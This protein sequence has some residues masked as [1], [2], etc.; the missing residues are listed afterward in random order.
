MNR[1]KRLLLA[2]LTCGLLILPLQAA[3]T[4][5]TDVW[6]VASEAG[7]GI[8]MIQAD[9]IIFI[10][11]FIYGSSGQPTWVVATMGEDANGNFA[12]DL[13]ATTGTYYGSPWNPINFV[14]T[15]VGTASFFPASPYA[16]TLSYVINGTTV[17]K[18]LQRQTLKTINLAGNYAGGRAGAYSGGNCSTVGE[19]QDNFNLQVSQ[20]GNGTSTFEFDYRSG[21]NCTLAGTLMQYGKLYSIP[22]ATYQCSNGLST[23]ASMDQVKA[24]AQGIEGTYA[25]PT[26]SAGCSESAAFSAVF[27]SAGSTSPTQNV[28][29]IS[30]DAGPAGVPNI[31]FVSVTVC[32]PG[33]STNCQTIDHIEID[34]GSSGLRLLSSVLSP[35]LSLPQQLDLHGDPLV[36]CIQFADGFSWGPV[37]LADMQIA[38]EQAKSIAVQIIGDPAFPTIPTSCSS[39]GPP[40]N[41]V[42]TFA[43]NGLIGVSQ[44]LQDCGSGCAQS[45]IPGFYYGCPA[46]GCYPTLVSVSEQLQNPVGLF[47]ADNNGVIIE[48]PSVPATGAAT[49]AG[50]LI[51][52]I[53]TQANNGLGSAKVL[54][55]DPSTGFIVTQFDNQTFVTS[56]ID[57]GS[58]V[59]Y[60]SNGLYPLCTTPAAAGL[61][62]PATTQNLSATLVG[63]NAT[64]TT[65]AFSIANADQLAA[66]PSLYAFSNLAAPGGNSTVF[67]WGLPFFY[68][69][70]VYTA[71]EQRSTPGGPGP[72]VAIQ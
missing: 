36:E 66:N 39:S 9:D 13:Y 37:K 70:N 61:Y 27:L 20:P 71:I 30:V 2:A 31:P 64:A 1:L 7:W 56:Y 42:A 41:T 24:T 44:F 49:A 11:F 54:T 33:S 65:A 10:S 60:I 5:Y 47:S 25:A 29:P 4:D 40:E 26:A 63:T 35:A 32:A 58:N 21:L 72:Y 51:F 22:S 38:G 8:D 62:C 48:L 18:A 15:L 16:G 50:S 3:A 59:L 53:G 23:T 45:L 55:T 12:G 19:Y 67:A 46:S 6:Y 28:Q 17:T 52:G 57:A 14:P 43:A 68:G 69:R 34:T